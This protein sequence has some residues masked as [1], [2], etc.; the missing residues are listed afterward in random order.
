MFDIE[1]F[2]NWVAL[3]DNDEEAHELV[4]VVVENMVLARALLGPDAAAAIGREVVQSGLV[5]AY[6]SA[7]EHEALQHLDLGDPISAVEAL[8]SDVDLLNFEFA[9]KANGLKCYAM[10]GM[11]ESEDPTATFAEKRNHLS[12]LLEWGRL[13]CEMIPEERTAMPKFRSIWAAAE[14]RFS[15]DLDRPVDIAS[16]AQLAALSRVGTPEQVRKTLQNQ[17]SAKQLT[18]NERRELIPSSALSFLKDTPGFPS[19]WML[20]EQPSPDLDEL[21]EPT[22]IPVCS[23]S[24]GERP[25]LPAEKH[26]DGYRVGSGTSARTID[27]YWEA[28][29]WLTQQPEPAFQPLGQGT[30]VRCKLEW[31]RVDRKLLLNELTSVPAS[32]APARSLTEQV[33][34]HLLACPGVGVH[35]LGHTSKLYRYRLK[36]GSEMALEK[37]IGEPWLY[38]PLLNMPT[39]ADVDSADVPGTKQGRNSNLDAM[40]TFVDQPLRKFR[41]TSIA[42]LHAVLGIL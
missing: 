11:I 13:I 4:S 20:Q 27:D 10:T 30:A 7:E 42:D 1:R 23:I 28:L 33:H 9:Q 29:D 26:A 31:A 14:A 12:E 24:M 34:Q 15:V 36:N 41:L 18:V 17:I 5:G 16:F 21:H 8:F 39:V 3:H 2:D 37:R 40:P 38:L 19:I 25:F 22:F 32:G 6:G 35:P